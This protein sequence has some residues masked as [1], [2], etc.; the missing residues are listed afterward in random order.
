MFGVD[1]EVHAVDRHPGYRT[2]RLSL[3]GAWSGRVEVQHHHAHVASV[4]VE[5][6]L[7]GSSPV[8]GFAFDGTGYGTDHA[9]SPQIWGGEV[10][11]ADYH[12]FDRVGHLAPLPLP[13]GDGAVR[14]PCR[15]AVAYLAA[16]GVAM[17]GTTA[18]EAACDDV[19]RNLVVRQVER[20]VGCQVTTSMGRL[21]DAVASLLGIRHRVTYEA[22]AAI[23]LEAVAD[24]GR[25]TVP[26]SFEIDD[27]G[28]IDPAPVLEGLISGLAG[29]QAVPDL[30]CSFHHA[31]AEA[32]GGSAARIAETTG[33]LPVALTG[34][35]FQNVLL[36]RLAARAL[37]SSGFEVLTHGVV[38]P[39]DGGLSLGQAVIAGCR[40]A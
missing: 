1:P 16:L 20:G 17:D 31:V 25:P 6:G 26:L 28:I 5:H 4:M 8:I 29:A 22:Q 39:N 12:G 40:R 7:D 11:V 36:T 32:I 19:E 24:R 27:H 33:R 23:E 30:A 34:G 10:L 13:G 18:S 14:N 35:V 2:H 38:P 3:D 9:G 15:V 37:T 21:F